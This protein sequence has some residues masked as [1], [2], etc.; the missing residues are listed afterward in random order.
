MWCNHKN[1]VHGLVLEN[2]VNPSDFMIC[3]LD[4]NKLRV[5]K[6]SNKCGKN[7]GKCKHPKWK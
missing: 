3:R 5:F 2:K 6:V 7:C 1:D 4:M